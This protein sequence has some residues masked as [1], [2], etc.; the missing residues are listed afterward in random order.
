MEWLPPHIVERLRGSH[1]LGIFVYLDLDPKPLRLWMGVNDVPAKIESVDEDGSVY[2]GAGRLREVP[3]LDVLINGIADRVAFTLSG[4]DPLD[5]MKIDFD[6]LDVRGR[7]LHVGITTL[8]DLYQPMSHIIPLWTGTASLVKEDSP[9]VG[10]GQKRTVSLSLSVGSGNTTRDRNSASIWSPAHQR[11]LY[12][13]DAFC[14]GTP[15]VARGV[16]P[17]WPRF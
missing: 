12:P 7:D 6:T 1:L 13:T 16:A 5:A 2:L 8:D 10:P 3:T 9:P 14:D 17:P 15:R 11:A 4:V